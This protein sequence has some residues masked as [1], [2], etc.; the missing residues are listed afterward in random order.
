MYVFTSVLKGRMRP[1]QPEGIGMW[2]W[3][4]HPQLYRAAAQQGQ[5]CAILLYLG[6]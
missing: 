2:K 6:M 1:V 4:S 3:F 5:R